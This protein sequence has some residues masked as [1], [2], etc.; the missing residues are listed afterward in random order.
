M[1]CNNFI[2]MVV[3]TVWLNHQSYGLRAVAAPHNLLLGC[4]SNRS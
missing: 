4:G 2:K 3:F 1:S